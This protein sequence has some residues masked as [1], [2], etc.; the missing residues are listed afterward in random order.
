MLVR[1]AVWTVPLFG[2][3]KFWFLPNFE[4]Y[5]E[6]A[7]CYTYGPITGLHLVFYFVFVAL[8]LLPAVLLAVFEGPKA[9]QLIQVG[10]YPLPGH[11]VYSK[12]K[13]VYGARA[14][15]RGYVLLATLVFLVGLSIKGIG[16]ANQIIEEASEKDLPS[17][18]ES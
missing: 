15:M 14:K 4:E 7:H 8:P 11:K 1:S 18:T 9:V 10:Q 17:C 12:T 5:A 3:T 16:S 2:L 13:Y 6:N